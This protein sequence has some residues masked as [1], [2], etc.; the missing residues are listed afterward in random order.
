M[1]FQSDFI[2]SDFLIIQYCFVLGNISLNI[3][4]IE[5]EIEYSF[6]III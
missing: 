3:L 6:I 4:G 1:R 2:R 5:I